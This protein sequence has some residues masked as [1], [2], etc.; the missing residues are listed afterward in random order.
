M[1]AGWTKSGVPGLWWKWTGKPGT[2]GSR[3]IGLCATFVDDL[4]ILGI[5][6]SSST[7]VAE[8]ARKGPFTIKETHPTDEG[9][10]RW[11]GVDFELKKDEIQISQSEYLQ[12]LGTSVPEGPIPSTPLPLNSRDRHDTSSPLSPPAV[13]QFRSLLGGLAWVARDTRPDLAEACNELSRSVACPTE[14]SHSFLHSAVRCVAATRDRSLS[15]R[16]DDI[17]PRSEKPL[18]LKGWGDA[19]LGTAGCAHPHTGWLLSIGNSLLHWRSFRQPRVACSSARAELYASHDLVDFLESLL[20][21]LRTVWQKGVTGTVYTDAKDILDLVGADRPRPS[22]RAVMK[23]IESLQEK[24]LERTLHSLVVQT[25][26]LRDAMDESKI[27]LSYV[28]TSENRADPL[29]K[30]I[31]PQLLSPFFHR[32]VEPEER[33]KQKTKRKLCCVPR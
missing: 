15:I 9:K 5:S 17:P 28:A 32:Y 14:R 18:H 22:E 19:A 20:L 2:A 10:V 12:S 13:K 29:T 4:A 27:R 24:L 11:A 16:R 8:I 31:S 26:S 30:S 1:E 23:V 25:L 21:C 33:E 7:L 3:L 6:I